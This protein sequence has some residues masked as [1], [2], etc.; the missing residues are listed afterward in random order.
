MSTDYSEFLSQFGEKLVNPSND[1]SIVA[2]SDV[3][4][5]KEVVSVFVDDPKLIELNLLDFNILIYELEK[6]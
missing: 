3:L 2:P 6:L 1:R 4:A 5:G